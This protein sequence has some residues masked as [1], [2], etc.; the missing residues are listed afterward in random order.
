MNEWLFQLVEKH[1]WILSVAVIVIAI[2]LIIFIVSAIYAVK[3]GRTITTPLFKI[4][5]KEINSP[6]N[7]A[8]TQT[9]S[10]IIQNIITPG[11]FMDSNI[12]EII[13]RITGQFSDMLTK[14]ELKA[15]V[16]FKPPEL[17]NRIGYLYSLR[18]YIGYMIS[19]IVQ[20]WGGGWPGVSMADFYTFFNLAIENKLISEDLRAKVNDFWQYSQVLLNSNQVPDEVFLDMQYLGSDICRQL[21][22]T[23]QR[24]PPT[25][26]AEGSVWSSEYPK[27]TN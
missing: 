19:Q 5:S 14:G 7:Q 6:P 8:S 10:A 4:G 1:P 26:G 27:I 12:D 25:P 23:L 22:S 24:I 11:L 13:A 16:L 3:Q 21:E 2:I 18:H 15:T 20:N 17:P 9:Q